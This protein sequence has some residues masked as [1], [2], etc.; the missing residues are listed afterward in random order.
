MAIVTGPF[1]S[2][3]ASG[4]IWKGIT[5]YP[6][7]AKNRFVMQK[8]KSRSGK[9]YPIQDYNASVFKSRAEAAK[10]AG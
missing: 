5:C 8:Y 4:S 3:W 6:R 7:Y 10:L 9:R 1:F 2:T